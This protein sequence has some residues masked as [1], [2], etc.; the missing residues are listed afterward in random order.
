MR[1]AL[2]ML[3][4][5]A[6]ALGLAQGALAVGTGQISGT[7][8]SA[9]VGKTAL[10]GI[11][12]CA[13]SVTSEEFACATTTGSGEYAMSGLAS[14]E[15][16]VEFAPPFERHLDYIPQYYDH[17]S[18]FAAA[19]PVSVTAG[20]TR[21]GVDAELEEGAQI[22]GT[23]RSALAGK[24]VIEGIR[25]CALPSN[26]RYENVECAKTNAAGEYTISA[27][28]SG[29]YRV[30]F[31]PPFESSLDYITQYYNHQPTLSSAQLVAVTA[32]FTRSGIDAELEEGG[33]II[34]RVTDASTGAP[35]PEVLVCASQG[36]AGTLLGEC[37][38]THSNGEYTISG[39]AS[40]NYKVGFNGAKYQVQYY[41]G[42]PSLAQAELVPVAAP[43]TTFSIDAALQPTATLPVNTSPP[44]VSGTAVVGGTL[45]CADG[46]WTGTPPPTFTQQWLRDGAPIAGALGSSYVAQAADAGH[47]VSCL[48][49]AKNSRGQ[50]S[51]SSAGV[52]VVQSPPL[53]SPA[54]PV[55]AI[56][57]SKLVV[58]HGS[59]RLR[60]TCSAAAC[61]GSVELTM[62][63]VVRSHKGRKAVSHKRTLIL[64]QGSFSLLPGS[65][66]NITLRLTSAGRKRLA[67]V[68]HHPI[69]AK[70]IVPVRGGLTAT[71][72]VVVS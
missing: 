42:K 9:S 22:T 66:A 27:L 28:Q 24:A 25:V 40:G 8:T 41:N 69:S 56:A 51:V 5:V 55:V 35:L 13:W 58:A 37:A 23:A 4:P 14:G 59:T 64:A 18:S 72:V 2:A 29:E 34:G 61:T 52:P 60:L 50:K 30:E 16:Y 62:R 53:P 15:Y 6:C 7:V 10:G 3:V 46:S 67:H 48:V 68:K 49:T 21:T 39:L 54:T 57:I 70:L 26:E 36:S 65:S 12:V 71:K 19:L 43:N 63:I 31:S 20:T 17:V 44:T 45:L 47:N 32:P 33:R 38:F 1:G 11:E